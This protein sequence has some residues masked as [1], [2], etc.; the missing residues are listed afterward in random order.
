MSLSTC[1]RVRRTGVQI[2]REKKASP[3]IGKFDYI[4]AFCYRAVTVVLNSNG[5]DDGSAYAGQAAVHL[6]GRRVND[7]TKSTWKLE[8]QIC[9]FQLCRR[10]ARRVLC[11]VHCYLKRKYFF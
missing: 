11:I 3:S 5:T 2:A 9:R 1:R 7:G 10:D 6:A 4:A 8:N